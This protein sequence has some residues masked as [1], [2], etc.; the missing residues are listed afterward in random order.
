[1]SYIPYIPITTSRLT[2]DD[3]MKIAE[4]ISQMCSINLKSEDYR[5]WKMIH[6]TID[7]SEYDYLTK[8]TNPDTGEDYVFPAK[9]R[10]IPIQRKNVNALVGMKAR[11]E[12]RF[13]LRASDS[14]TIKEKE[15]NHM[16][17]LINFYL[18]TID[19]KN[20]EVEY[21]FRKMG[22]QLSKMQ[23][24][25]QQAQQ[26]AQQIQ[27]QSQESG[28][29]LDPRM[30]Q[31]VE[32]YMQQLEE[33][34]EYFTDQM[35]LAQ[36]SYE[37]N[38]ILDDVQYEE[39]KQQIAKE[40][41]DV[42]DRYVNILVKVYRNKLDAVR[43]SESIF[44]YNV[45]TGKAYLYV[46]IDENGKVDY[47]PMDSTKV[48]YPY[49]EKVYWIHRG[50]WQAIRERWSKSSFLQKYDKYLD[51]SQRNNYGSSYGS[52]N[53]VP[54]PSSGAIPN[55]GA[56]VETDTVDVLRIW[57]KHARKI[58]KKGLEYVTID[59]E[60]TDKELWLQERY[61]MVMGDNIFVFGEVDKI[62][63]R[64]YD[65]LQ[66]VILP[67]V[68]KSYSGISDQSYSPVNITRELAELYMILH[69]QKELL[70]VASGVKG[71]IVDKS[72]VPD[73]MSDEEHRY[74]KKMGTLYIKTMNADG[75]PVNASFN[76]WK[77]YDDTLP[78]SVQIIES[79]CQ[80]I[81]Q[82]IG[83][84]MGTPTQM[85]GQVQRQDQVGTFEMSN[86]QAM[87]VTETLFRE[88]DE[89]ET[90]A[91]SVL[92][93]IL[94]QYKNS[95]DEIAEIYQND[96]LVEFA[97][98]PANILK[99]RR[100][101]IYTYDNSREERS[102]KELKQLV[103]NQS[104]QGILPFDAVLRLYDSYSLKDLKTSIRYI[105]KQAE[106]M[107]E[108]AQ[109]QAHEQQLEA[110]AA[111]I[112][113]SQEYEMMRDKVNNQVKQL[114][115]ELQNAIE[116]SKLKLQEEALKLKAQEIGVN[117]NIDIAKMESEAAVEM[118]Y[119]K[120]QSEHQKVGLNLDA[121]RLKLET[122][123]NAMDINAYEKVESKKAQVKTYGKEKIK[124]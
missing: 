17:K 63:P 18:A 92:A 46:N 111:S 40:D 52:D 9:L 91:M 65:E 50:K 56:S 6:G 43:K 66:D 23:E 4:A 34:I 95:E 99:G 124:D 93:N 97:K 38:R 19:Q 8:M 77:S 122:M 117:A 27:Q 54:T 112:K 26:Q 25:Y 45:V 29:E 57:Y 72:Q 13:M 102:I 15:A 42:Y 70:I 33:R 109:Q 69:Y 14:R 61:E 47:D 105:T 90:E 22:K 110:Q 82:Q 101:T 75:R 68:G 5:A 35:E 37:S 94:G 11:R 103:L 24:A 120:D 64:F 106:M 84:M 16:R 121:L 10:W 78:Q 21:Q 1:M 58:N 3:L 49:D 36:K 118:A 71:D 85:L 39:I 73:K 81:D 31:Q 12:F 62:Q 30:M 7:E 104:N 88:C 123:I 67:I 53:F 74:H 55:P 60:N 28:E 32:G 79:M 44:K 59:T 48:F 83:I 51:E 107:R 80:Q 76:Q 87:I 86:E 2:K 98:V 119:L 20:K 115:I 116:K 114:Q 89:I 100:F 96:E 41:V 113:A 108:K